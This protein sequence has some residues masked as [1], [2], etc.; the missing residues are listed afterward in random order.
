MTELRIGGLYKVVKSW[1]SFTSDGNLLSIPVF[2]NHWSGDKL[3]YFEKRNLEYNQPFLLLKIDEPEYYKILFND[4]I[5]WVNV[6]D[7]I[8]ELVE[9][10]E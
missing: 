8:E 7:G 2:I 10:F 1:R 3:P 9:V 6:R 5:G 4:F